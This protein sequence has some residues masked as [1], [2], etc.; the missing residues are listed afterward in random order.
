[1]TADP[2]LECGSALTQ[3]GDGRH[4]LQVQIDQ[5]FALLGDGSHGLAMEPVRM[6][7]L[8][9]TL[10][11]D[12]GHGLAVEPVRVITLLSTLLEEVVNQHTDDSDQA[13]P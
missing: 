2:C 7:T 10:L 11:H 4:G 3:R 12:R 13:R 8:R 1:M 5:A 6:I 9:S